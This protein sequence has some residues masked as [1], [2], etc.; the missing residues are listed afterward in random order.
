MSGTVVSSLACERSAPALA[1]ADNGNLGNPTVLDCA[2]NF[3]VYRV[4][5]SIH[6]FLVVS[7]DIITLFIKLSSY[8][9]RPVVSNFT[10]EK[11]W[12]SS[13]ACLLDNN[14]VAKSIAGGQKRSTTWKL[15][16]K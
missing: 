11:S 2:Y 8:D 10:I 6:V 9:K 15:L 4:T 5:Q 12:P 13:W 3:I 16:L 1:V 7:M 14:D